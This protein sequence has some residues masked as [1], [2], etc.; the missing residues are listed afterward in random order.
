VPFRCNPGEWFAVQLP[1]GTLAA[2][3]VARR[4]AW[5]FLGY[6]FGPRRLDQPALDDVIHLRAND[7]ILIE[8]VDIYPITTGKFPKLGRSAEF[9][10][11][12]WPLP[13]F[14]YREYGSDEYWKEEYP[15]PHLFHQPR[16]TRITRE[17]FARLPS[18]G[19]SSSGALIPALDEILPP[20]NQVA[21]SSQVAALSEMNFEEGDWCGIPL[22]EDRWA[23]GRIV[24]HQQDRAVGFFLAHGEKFYPRSMN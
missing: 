22:P 15:D 16:K 17:E 9:D 24:H 6:F 13:A 14:G 23:I 20:V 2:G 18:S 12:A 8:T 11:V 5:A 19:I 7:S 1:D 4:D 10:P 21:E 3:H